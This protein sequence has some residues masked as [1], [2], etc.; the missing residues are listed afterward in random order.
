[1]SRPHIVVVGAGPVGLLNALG[2][3]MLG[4]RVTVLERELDVVASPRAITYLWFVMDGLERLGILD[5]LKE[6]GV[7]TT[8]G[9]QVLVPST[10]ERFARPGMERFE[11]LVPHPFNVH[12]GQD[13]LAKIALAHFTALPDTEV[14]WN[15]AVT[16][17]SQDGDGVTV[18]VDL[19]EQTRELQADWLV[20][21][22]GA[23]STVR[24][25]IVGPEFPGLTW[26]E[27]FVATNIRYDLDSY[28]YLSA[29]LVI[30]P[31]YG[32]IVAKIDNDNLWRLTYT[33]DLSLPQET[34]LDRMP[35]VLSHILPGRGDYELVHFSPYRTHQRAADTFR[36]GRVVLA[37]DAA[38]I[39]NPTGGMGL[40]AGLLD[41]FVLYEALSAVALGAA[42]D[43]VL[44]QYSELRRAVFLDIVSPAATEFR[45]LVYHSDDPAR[46]ETDLKRMRPGAGGTPQDAVA[47]LS[48]I[49]TPSLLA[50]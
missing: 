8:D 13:R 6:T 14:I 10:G 15:A 27:R 36:I 5:D 39:T 34:V 18:K 48:R 33:E 4:H 24:K 3:A 30:D 23:D 32:A 47:G 31:N 19:G 22:D 17:V 20:G 11:G 49:K 1:M 42:G 35:G 38:H 37:G 43:Q 16:E 26:P 25:R 7:V 9:Q 44:D 45:R 46:L 12:L 21:A 2:L 40:T 28:G 50:G 29:N 41:T